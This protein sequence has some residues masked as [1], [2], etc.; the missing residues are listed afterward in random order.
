[1]AAGLSGAMREAVMR[2]IGRRRPQY[3]GVGWVRLENLH[4]TLAFLGAVD[5]LRLTDV[6]A[7]CGLAAARHRPFTFAPSGMGVF[8]PRGR[9]RVYWLGLSQ[10]EAE[11]VALQKDVAA[12]LS[13]RKFPLEDRAFV[14]HLTLGR[15]KE[16]RGPLP[17]PS[18]W[19][20]TAA[21]AATLDKLEVM[22]SDL[23]PTGAVYTVLASCPLK[24]S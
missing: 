9:P 5:E 11:M 1:V 22:R 21:P 12:E 18:D 2:E 7:A 24:I 4:F 8:P 19:K 17:N 6:I 23:K 3:P 15:V 10:G 14:P 13:A 20:T 16:V